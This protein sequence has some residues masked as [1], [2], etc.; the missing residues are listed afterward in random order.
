MSVAEA[1]APE[2]AYG[3][4]AVIEGVVIRGRRTVGL[5]VRKPSGA[6]YRYREPL[7]SIL[8]RSRLARLPLAR[9]LVVLWETLVVGVRMLMRS[10]NV[11]LEEEEVKL[12]GASAAGFVVV[13][14]AIGVGLFIAVPY[15]A[16]QA[17]RGLVSDPFW[18]NLVEGLFRLALFLGYIVAISFLPDIRRVFA[19]HGAE[20]MT[21][22]AYEHGDALDPARI[23]RYPTAHPR[24]GTAFLLFVVVVSI[25]AFAFVERTNPVLALVERVVLVVPV[26]AVSYEILRFGGRY[27]TFALIAPLLWP[28]LLLQRLTTR[29]PTAAMIEVAIAS[30]EEALAGDAER[31]PRPTAEAA[32]G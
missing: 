25:V 4:Q 28:G 7:N 29:Q 14:L 24:C 26:A 3:G 11:A 19:Y 2:F 21:I 12:E 31:A 18:Q 27:P 5:A 20:H 17:L 13:A 30:L 32:N 16:T 6:V 10:A 23:A 8:Q 1:R 15:V 9:G 22:H